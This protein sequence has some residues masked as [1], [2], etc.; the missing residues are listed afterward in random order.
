MG[1]ADWRASGIATKDAKN[2]Q[3]VEALAAASACLFVRAFVT[4]AATALL[5]FAVISCVY[6]GLN[7]PEMIAMTHE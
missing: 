4:N 3:V 5:R 6:W 7:S 2:I 1:T